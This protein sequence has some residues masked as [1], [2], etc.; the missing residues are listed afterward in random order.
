MA[1]E[2]TARKYEIDLR[3]QQKEEQFQ[4]ALV[5]AQALRIDAIAND[6]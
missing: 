3:L 2:P 5:L 1:V 6:G 4:D